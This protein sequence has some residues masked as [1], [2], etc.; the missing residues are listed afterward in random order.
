MA[1]KSHHEQFAQIIERF[2]A[3]ADERVIASLRHCFA[4][5][6]AKD[7]RRALLKTMDLFRLVATETAEQLTYAYPQTADEQATRWVT[8][9][10]S[11]NNQT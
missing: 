4:H 7:V 5:Y 8:T 9:K 1:S 2:S 11:Q 6:E 10:L 3:W